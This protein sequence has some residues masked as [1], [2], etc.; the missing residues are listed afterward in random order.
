MTRKATWWTREPWR[1]PPLLL[2]PR[3]RPRLGPPSR[4]R[5][6]KTLR[7]WTVIRRRS[8]SRRVAKVSWAEGFSAWTSSHPC[9]K[10]RPSWSPPTPRITTRRHPR[11]HLREEK[12]PHRE[13]KSK[14]RKAEEDLLIRFK[15]QSVALPVV[16]EEGPSI[17][18]RTPWAA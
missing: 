2:S 9:R 8:R 16:V 11:G 12:R 15:I 14:E 1:T 4:R 13:K 18:C 10:N 5:V 7:G 17:R 6:P 3:P